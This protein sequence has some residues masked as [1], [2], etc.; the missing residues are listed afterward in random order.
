MD[1]LRNLG[2]IR[3]AE[4]LR[5]AEG[6]I[7]RHTMAMVYAHHFTKF[8]VETLC[9]I[10]RIVFDT[11]YAWAGEFRTISFVKYE[12]VLGGDTVHYAHPSQIRKELS[13]AAKEIAR[14][15]KSEPKRC[16]S[17]F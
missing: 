2:N 10:H 6:D 1:V 12:D 14:L 15:K 8:N 7:T 16:L 4:E 5:Q 17:F 11:L 3:D 13:E 9:E